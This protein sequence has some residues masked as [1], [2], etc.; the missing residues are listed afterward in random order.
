VRTRLLAEHLGCGARD[1]ADRIEQ[2]GALIPA[3]EALRR[4]GERTLEAFTADERADALM[5]DPEMLDPER[6][7]DA[8][9][10]AGELLPE[11]EQP[12]AARRIAVI[13]VL[14]LAA[15]AL[16]AAWRWGPLSDIVD[17]EALAAWGGAAKDS[18]LA[19]LLVLGAFVAAS[20]VAM[21]IT[22]LILATAFVFGPLEGFAY[23]LAGSLL[24]A[25]V[26]FWLGR[27]LGRGTVRR[28]AGSRLNKLS[29]LLGRRGL[30]AVITVRILPVA[31]F[32][33]VNM[34]AGASH[35]RPRDFLIGTALGMLPGIVAV[36]LFSDRLAAAVFEPTAGNFAWFALALVLIAAAGLILY[37]WLSRRAE[38]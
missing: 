28:L 24:G 32:T 21:P 9:R 13:T 15:G 31:P 19:P 37:R 8:E 16:A 14:L 20:L 23:A 17:L 29:R 18:I 12:H 6:P 2:E 35:L 33:L 7:V 4:P 10:L 30:L 5:P 26:T 27:A 38:V 3:L 1:V 34:V 25:G 11:D 36:V 22:L